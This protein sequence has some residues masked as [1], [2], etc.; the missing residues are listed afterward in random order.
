MNL[1][2]IL[3]G[4]FS[5]SL[6]LN[7]M[8]ICA[9]ETS[10]VAQS[11]DGTQTYADYTSA[12]SAANSGTEIIMLQDWNLNDRLIV[13][14]GATVTIDMNGYKI[15]RQ[16]SETVDDGEVI[17]V[18]KGSSLTLNGSTTDSTFTVK[19][20][21]NDS[22]R[23]EKTTEVSS[24]GMITGGYSSNGGAG[25][26][27]KKNSTLTL[28]HVA[29]SGNYSDSDF[30]NGGGI[31]IDNSGCTVNLN[32]GTEVSYNQSGE[33]GGI[34]V[35]GEDAYIFMNASKISNNFA[36]DGGGIYSNYDATRIVLDNGSEISDNT[37][38]TDGGGV[39]FYNSYNL[40]KS[41]DSTGKL[42]NNL[43][44]GSSELIPQGGAVYY[45]EVNLKSNEGYLE[46]LT[47]E[48]NVVNR[49]NSGRG[50]AVYF[51]LKNVQVTNCT[52][53]SNIAYNGGAFYQNAKDITLIDCTITDNYSDGRGGAAYVDSL[54][55]L[56]LKGKCIIKDNTSFK[57]YQV[58][59]KDNIYLQT[60]SASKAYV[61]GT[62]DE[63]SSVWI[64]ADGERQI[65]INQGN[66]NGTFH[67]DDDGYYI[68]YKGSDLYKKSGTASVFGNGNTL[69]AGCVMLG[70]GVIG[71]VIL[72]V[73]KKKKKA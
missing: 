17:Y 62:P 23:G 64:S 1:K 8:S 52:F 22:Y 70:I 14:E 55:N 67:L 38:H 68:Y 9:E 69:I 10:V 30:N 18:G 53:K 66:T 40:I 49:S 16:L 56:I 12:W 72:F 25:I 33:G 59:K 71:G 34:Y 20:F 46:N 5:L 11:A 7:P 28:D 6:V 41:N 3:T 44:E 51:D 58:T 37:A 36:S 27:M 65:G 47:F 2:K 57:Y 4:L 24:G 32:N 15:D 54:D 31:K 73:N 19:D 26:H 21:K 45:H 13:N 50:G 60:G 61:S 42:C 43:C 29:V 63:G 48:N 35:G 39:Y